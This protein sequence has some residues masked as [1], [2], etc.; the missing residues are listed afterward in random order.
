MDIGLAHQAAP[1]LYARSGDSG[2]TCVHQQALASIGQLPQAVDVSAGLMIVGP[3]GF[4]ISPIMAC[5]S[6]RGS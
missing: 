3:E 6:P 4:Y 5:V 2:K 1:L